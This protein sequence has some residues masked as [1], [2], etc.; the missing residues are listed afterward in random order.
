MKVLLK[1][2]K[3]FLYALDV[4]LSEKQNV[5]GVKYIFVNN[6]SKN[7]VIIFDGIGGDYNYR[8][9]L[10]NSRYDQLYIKDNWASG[11]SYYLYEN[12]SNHPEIAVTNFVEGF[13]KDHNYEK[14]VTMGSS[15]GGSCAIF[16]GL[17]HGVDEVY[18]GACQYRVGNYLGIYHENKGSGYYK[19]VMG[20][21]EINTGIEILNNAFRNIIEQNAG[22]RTL[23][24]L[25][26]STEEHTY[27]DDIVPLICKLDEC[28][29]RH[30]DQVENFPEHSMIGDY[31]K[32][33]CNKF[34]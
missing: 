11:T 7:L 5:D 33:L 16:Y 2:I 12:G 1:K 6:R 23:V 32:L 8:K 27:T 14:I 21:T 31:M 18:S 17:K 28:N 26:Y 30:I 4:K 9:S 34:K 24:H 29:I 19:K 15:K 22:S 20:N 25:I 10:R 3:H 13:I